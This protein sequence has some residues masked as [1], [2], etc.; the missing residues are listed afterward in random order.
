MSEHIIPITRPNAPSVT[1]PIPNKQESK[2]PT[3]VINLPSKGYFYPLNS[4]LSNGTLELKMITAKEEDI[5]TSKNLLQKNLTLDKLLESVI[6]DRNIKPDE[7]LTCDR[8][9]AFYAIRRLAYGDNYEA[10]VTC[11]RCGKGNPIS[12]DLG[13]MDNKPFD[14]SNYTKG[15]NSFNFKLPKSGVTL[16]YKILNRN[17]ENVIEQELTGLQK[18][19]KEIT[20]DLTTRYAHIITAIDGN[21]E[22]VRIRKFV[23]EEFLSI[24]SLAFRT[25]LASNMPDLDT[26][27][28]FVCSYCGTEKK[29]ETPMG[30]TFF[31]PKR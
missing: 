4:P 11:G 31:W 7:M 1:S 8:N 23:N 13:K 18:I 20:R 10:T 5:L 2:F 9:A 22:K 25:H 3:E 17:D 28:D 26:T 6:I 27:F 24:D 15:E 29:E 12:I 21:S 30:P 16:T 19:N 14:F